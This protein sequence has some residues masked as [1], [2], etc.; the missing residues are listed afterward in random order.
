MCP[1]HLIRDAHG[2]AIEILVPVYYLSNETTAKGPGRGADK[3]MRQLA[4]SINNRGTTVCTKSTTALGEPAER[5]QR[6]ELGNS[7][8]SEPLRC[9]SGDY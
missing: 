1:R 4:T 6:R 3:M 9:P 5:G 8:N 7:D 2:R